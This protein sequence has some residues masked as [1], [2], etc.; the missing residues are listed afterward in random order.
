VNE[1]EYQA[2]REGGIPYIDPT[3]Q[4]LSRGYEDGMNL[5]A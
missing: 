4:G 5:L 3:Y 1:T 2:I